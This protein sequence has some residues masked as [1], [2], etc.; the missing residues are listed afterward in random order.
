AARA[1]GAPAPGAGRAAAPAGALPRARRSHTD[2]VL[3]DREP[4][5]LGAAV[6][7]E[8]PRVL[9]LPL[10]RPRGPAAAAADPRLAPDRLE[11]ESLRQGRMLGQ[12]GSQPCNV[13][14]TERDRSTPR[15]AVGRV[16][17]ADEPLAA[18]GLQQLH[19]RREALVARLLADGQLL[20]E[21][22]RS[23]RCRRLCHD[24]DGTWEGGTSVC[25]LPAES[26]TL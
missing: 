13:S 18:R 2:R 16:R 19:D 26:V 11:T 7:P 12:E 23:P 25:R 6:R 15:R 10:P 9:R 8:R 3:F 22:R 17:K 14:L 20:D 5:R 1:P 24:D 4:Q 21:I